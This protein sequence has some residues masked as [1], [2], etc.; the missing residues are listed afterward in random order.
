ML[1]VVAPS[2]PPTSPA[3]SSTGPLR[4]D[5]VFETLVERLMAPSRLIGAASANQIPSPS[6][7][8]ATTMVFAA[9]AQGSTG[10]MLTRELPSALRLLGLDPEEPL[11]AKAIEQVT[12][13][14]RGAMGRHAFGVF[15]HRP[16]LHPAFRLH[17]IPGNFYDCTHYCYSPFLYQAVWWALAKG[18]AATRSTASSLINK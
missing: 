15:V 13:T 8:S 10:F 7:G 6:A 3:V 5:V 16:D 14:S 4:K 17:G 9:F 11:A 12:A 1:C 2:P 18:A